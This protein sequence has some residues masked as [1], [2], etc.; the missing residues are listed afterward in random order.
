MLSAK[1]VCVLAGYNEDGSIISLYVVNN[2]LY[3]YSKNRLMCLK[4]DL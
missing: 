2:I 4:V 1:C 3:V